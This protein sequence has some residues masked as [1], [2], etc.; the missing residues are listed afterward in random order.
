MSSKVS[1]DTLCEVVWEVLHRNQC[2]RRKFLE[3]VELQISLKN[4][5]PQKDKRFSGCPL[6]PLLFN[7]VLKVLA[8]AIRQEKEIKDI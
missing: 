2:K 5:D 7:I 3:T 8:R 6:S 1:H 4:Y